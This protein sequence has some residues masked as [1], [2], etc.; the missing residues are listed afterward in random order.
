M[1]I[2]HFQC[3]KLRIILYLRKEYVLFLTF[4]Y[5]VKACC[6]KKPAMLVSTTGHLLRS[7]LR[8]IYFPP[9]QKSSSAF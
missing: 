4:F 2:I 7:T 9:F 8:S 5:K 3:V 6:T 1:P